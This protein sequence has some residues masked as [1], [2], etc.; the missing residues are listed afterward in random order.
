MCNA[1]CCCFSYHTL[2]EL[3]YE[4]KW[5]KLIAAKKWAQDK[6]ILVW[7]ARHHLDMD[8]F[9]DEYLW[10]EASGLQ[11]PFILQGMFM[12]AETMGQKEREWAIH[13]G[14]WQALPR[15]D[16]KADVPAIQVMGFKTTW[17]EIWEIYNDVY[18]LKRL[19]GPTMWPRMGWRTGP[20][21][22][23]LLEGAPVVEDGV[24]PCQEEDKNGVPPEPTCP[25]I[26]LRPLRRN[27][28]GMMVPVTVPLPKQGRLIG[29]HWWPPT[30]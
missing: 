7:E 10:W 8:L 1:F 30:Y 15:L 25:I 4:D 2:L 22:H 3:Y 16:T 24:P 14:H 23:D 13:Q 9:L 17:R 28:R 27:N 26:Q 11:C 12:H 18:Q 20:R 6:G 5:L 19:P 29:G 21:K